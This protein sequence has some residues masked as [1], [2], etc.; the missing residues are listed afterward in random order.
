MEHEALTCMRESAK[1]WRDE[2]KRLLAENGRLLRQNERLIDENR[3]LRFALDRREN[4]AHPE[5]VDAAQKV[6]DAY[7]DFWAER[8]M[9]AARIRGDREAANAAERS[10]R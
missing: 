1:L 2:A 5:Y 8:A 6:S 4:T 7:S 3:A 9:L 10:G